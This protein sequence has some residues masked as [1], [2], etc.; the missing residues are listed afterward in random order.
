V[1]SRFRIGNAGDGR[2]VVSA[3]IPD[4]A[5]RAWLDGPDA[6][7]PGAATAVVAECRAVAGA[8]PLRRL[9][10]RS[11]D[12]V[13]PDVVLPVRVP[14]SAS[15]VE[16]AFLHFGYVPIG[17]AVTR[18]IRVRAGGALTTEAEALAIESAPPGPGGATTYRVRFSPRAPGLVRAALASGGDGPAVPVTGVGVRRVAAFPAVVRVPS[19]VAEGLPAIMLANVA[20]EPLAITGVELPDGLAGEVRTIVAGEQFRLAL[21][22]TG[23]ALPAGT[24]A[25]RVRTD[26]ADEP[27]LVV[28]VLNGAP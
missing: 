12:P 20:A 8:G 13:D 23:A 10:L 27:V 9:R 26:A 18:E 5:C 24:S 11:N 16:P 6:L 14:A 22:R 2:L 28:P 21:R 19:A 1:R 3:V 15:P 25:I 7:A 4:C 17:G